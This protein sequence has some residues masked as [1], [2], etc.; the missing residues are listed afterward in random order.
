MQVNE[1]G[2]LFD[3]NEVRFVAGYGNAIEDVPEEVRQGLMVMVGTAYAHR[4]E[5]VTGTVV[6]AIPISMAA[7]S[8]FAPYRIVWL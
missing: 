4:E 2:V 1:Q 7:R 5:I 8:L 3:I 6:A